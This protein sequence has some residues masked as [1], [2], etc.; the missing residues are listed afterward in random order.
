MSR[1]RACDNKMSEKDCT[2]VEYVFEDGTKVFTDYCMDCR[3]ESSMEHSVLMKEY[4][5]DFPSLDAL[6]TSLYYSE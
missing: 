4:H 5:C 6:P 2:F 1:C 3:F